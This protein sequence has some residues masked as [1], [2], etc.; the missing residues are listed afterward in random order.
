MSPEVADIPSSSIQMFESDN[1]NSG[2]DAP[3]NR[4]WCGIGETYRAVGFLAENR[5]RAA[6]PLNVP[7]FELAFF[8]I[9]CLLWVVSEKFR[10]PTSFS[11]DVSLLLPPSEYSDR[12]EL[13]RILRVALPDFNSPSGKM[14]LELGTFDC[15]PEGAGVLLYLQDMPKLRLNNRTS[16]LIMIGYRNASLISLTG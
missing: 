13:E 10:L 2:S 9:L 6:A 16:T 4:A 5:F 14:S 3:E 1:F 15:K 11:I 7:K 12:F 8:K